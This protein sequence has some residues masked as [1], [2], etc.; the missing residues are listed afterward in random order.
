[1]NKQMSSVLVQGSTIPES[2]EMMTWGEFLNDLLTKEQ[3]LVFKE[4]LRVNAKVYFY[5][6][7]LGKSVIAEVLQSFGFRVSESGMYPS[8]GPCDV[9]INKGYIC[10]EVKNKAPE[11]LNIYL[12]EQLRSQK[13]VFIEWIQEENNNE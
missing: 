9:P 13:E 10:F 3:I 1:M 7:G 4:A 5:G 8:G 6:T 12:R 11:K 2:Q